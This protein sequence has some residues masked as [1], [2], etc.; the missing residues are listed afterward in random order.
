MQERKGTDA[1]ICPYCGKPSVL[2]RSSAEVYHGRDYGPIWVCRPCGAWVGTHKN[3][4]FKPLG[5]M[6][7]AELRKWKMKAHGAFDPLWMEKQRREGCSKTKARKAAYA[8]MANEM[9]IRPSRC[10]IGMMDVDQCK[11][12]VEICGRYKVPREE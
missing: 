10:H 11:L 7:N 3:S 12:V 9:G 8:W 2:L 6:A 1:P 5:R 4:R